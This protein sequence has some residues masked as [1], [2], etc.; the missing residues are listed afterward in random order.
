MLAKQHRISGRAFAVV[1]QKG[2]RVS[3]KVVSMQYFFHG[4]SPAKCACVV[5]KRVAGRAV[6]R[7]KLRR[8][9]YALLRGI[10][11]TLPRGAHIAFFLRP[12]AKNASPDELEAAVRE[13]LGRMR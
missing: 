2:R 5:S 1:V 9:C 10:H 6:L 4:I 13:L 11:P 7:N 12:E 3:H 8:R